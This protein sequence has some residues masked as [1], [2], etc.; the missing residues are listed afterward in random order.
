MKNYIQ[1]LS[2]LE[3]GMDKEYGSKAVTLALILKSGYNVPDGYCIS[4]K[5]L[6]VFTSQF[7]MDT[8][9][10]EEMTEK[11]LYSN[12]PEDLHTEIEEMWTKLDL[13]EN[14]ALIVRSSAIGEDG[15]EHSFA[16][17]YESIINI[18]SLND[19]IIGIR[20]CWRSFYST[21]ADLYREKNKIAVEGMAV[22][23][24]RM[25]CGDYSGVLFTANPLA[26][27][28]DEMVIEAYPGLNCGVVDGSVNADKYI[29]KN[30][31]EI[32]NRIIT[33]KTVEYCLSRNSFR[34][35]VKNTRI[36]NNETLSQEDV[37]QLVKIGLKLEEKFGIP[38]DIEWT[39]LNSKMYILQTRPVI[40]KNLDKLTNIIKYDSDIAED[41]E[42][43]LLDR[44]AQP[45]CTCYLS[46]LQSWEEQVYLSFY[47]KKEGRLYKEK[48]LLFYF[49]RVYWNMK[50]QR[51][52]F[53][54]YPK[55]K[56][57][58]A[59]CVKVVKLFFLMKNS[60]ISW[61]Q[62]LAKYN[63]HIE[64]LN[65][66]PYGNMSISRLGLKLNGILDIF[67]NYIGKDHFIFLGLAQVTYNLL[68]KELEGLPNTKE[69]ISEAIEPIVSQNMTMKS[70]LELVDLAW[71]AE[72][73]T[74]IS[75]LFREVNT[76]E[77]YLKLKGSME[78]EGF[79]RRF[80]KFIRD[81][82]H[83]GTSC[84]D[85]YHPHWVDEP[86]IV[87]ETIKQFICSSTKVWDKKN[88]KDDGKNHWN[89]SV[90]RYIRD[91]EHNPVY[92]HLKM[93]QIN[94]LVDLTGKYM[95]LRENQ[96]YYF[97]KSWVLIRRVL[98]EIGK[99]L[100]SAGIIDEKE[101]IFHLTISEILVISHTDNMLNHRDWNEVI[102]E[103]EKS[104][105][106]NRKITPP[107]LIKN[108]D[109][110]RLQK[111]GGRN[112]YKALGISPGKA[113][114]PVKIIESIK[115]LSRIQ[116]GDIAIVSTF[117]PSWTPILGI[118]K[119]LVMDYGN[120][121]SH[122]AVM[123]REYGIPVV[124]FNDI[125]AQVFLEGQWIEIDGS[126]GR[127]RVISSQKNSL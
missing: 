73:S 62:R 25:I 6:E 100:V 92:K 20:K 12:F 117:H 126:T 94:T 107:Y 102:K 84:D 4:I 112:S 72:C 47:N 119:G 113:T 54:D 58:I 14:E 98:L 34:I 66:Q 32:I 89:S 2:N 46:L 27:K 111:G 61:Y 125:A 42:C 127:I 122:G 104:Y 48:P 123:A 21:R 97:D 110:I 30:T 24:Q 90:E 77:I 43:T 118:V 38:C 29:V 37:Y 28:N 95:A 68:S 69:I 17:I 19:L 115:D 63:N 11:I 83:R 13:K 124:V 53:D 109:L 9:S 7:Q 85:L 80:D 93:S 78:K 70:N 64:E 86:A 15:N 116:Q 1:H 36:Q 10:M 103:R 31:G 99:R 40:I 82:G 91:L 35:D 60:Y 33:N 44:Y 18:R 65:R 49:N 59:D 114:G 23:V 81:H 121:L 108:K 8:L 96:R 75:N 45:A 105:E 79:K 16:G 88:I 106:K 22:I 41:I 55:G 87:M 76:D 5:A 51:D 50:Y 120:I 57:N 101:D 56:L 71:E 67:C 39:A 52:F 26:P 3:E 74:E